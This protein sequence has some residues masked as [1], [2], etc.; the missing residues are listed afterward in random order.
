MEK[1]C[2]LYSDVAT[3]WK[4][5]KVFISSQIDSTAK[6]GHPECIK[7]D[8]ELVYGK[9]LI[10]VFQCCNLLKTVYS[11]FITSRINITKASFYPE[12]IKTWMFD[13]LWMSNFCCVVLF[14][15][16][17]T[18]STVFSKLLH[19]NTEKTFF[20][21]TNSKSCLMHSGCPIFA[22]LSIWDEIII[23]DSF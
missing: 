4:L 18:L 15:M 11:V 19:W 1:K 13:S 20:P 7:H 12:C 3:C 22:V 23:V 14:E 10:S 5:S 8:L 17:W 16:K 21:Y 9:V 2:F 6:I